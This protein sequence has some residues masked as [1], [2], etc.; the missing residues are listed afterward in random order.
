MQIT[1]EMIREFF[2]AIKG[3][4]FFHPFPFNDESIEMIFAAEKDV[5]KFILD[6]DKITGMYMLRGFDSGYDIPSF[7]VIVHPEFRGK[8]YG[9]KMLHRA[10]T[11]SKIVGCDSIRLTVDSENKV[12]KNMYK[13]AGFKFTNNVGIKEL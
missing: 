7:G 8:G 3:D 5:Y 1:K 9:K 12:A 13:K 4:K 10:I 6:G 11:L 2:K